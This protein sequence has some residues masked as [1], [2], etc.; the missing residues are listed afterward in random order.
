MQISFL[1]WQKSDTGL[2]RDGK[3]ACGTTQHDYPSL[4]HSLL[5]P[6]ANDGGNCCGDSPYA[7]FLLRY[8]SFFHS[9]NALLV[10][11]YEVSSDAAL[12]PRCVLPMQM[13][14]NPRTLSC[15]G[16]PPTRQ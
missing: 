5:H 13:P 3:W 8:E 11:A 4:Y 10:L 1:K 12:F 7:P 9:A 2:V 14:Q 6:C 15:A 16:V